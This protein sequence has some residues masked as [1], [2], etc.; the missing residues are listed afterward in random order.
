MTSIWSDNFV[1]SSTLEYNF[2]LWSSVLEIDRLLECQL[3]VGH[4]FNRD[5][6]HFLISYQ[7]ISVE[8]FFHNIE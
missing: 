3:S 1:A 6:V 2:Y 8:F 5:N 7:N 4:E